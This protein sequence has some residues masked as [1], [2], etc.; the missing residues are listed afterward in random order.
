MTSAERSRPVKD[1][2]S[3]PVFS[4]AIGVLARIVTEQGAVPLTMKD[5]W[6]IFEPSEFG[7]DI[8]IGRAAKINGMKDGVSHEIDLR[9]LNAASE[10][11]K[12][13]DWVVDIRIRAA[14]G[15]D[16]LLEAPTRVGEGAIHGLVWLTINGTAAADL[17][18]GTEI[19]SDP[20][21]HNRLVEIVSAFGLPADIFDDN[22]MFTYDDEAM[23]RLT[24]E[25]P[26]F[27]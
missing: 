21:K 6:G 22:Q 5:E 19:S 7:S 27:V 25:L 4:G 17:G 11:S 15:D 1:K 26:R 10:A 23:L 13:N 14:E 20:I 8:I 3:N 2:L 18:H 9:L 12:Y 16:P 24:E